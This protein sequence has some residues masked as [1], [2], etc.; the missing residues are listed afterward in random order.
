MIAREFQD[1]VP[2][3]LDKITKLAQILGKEYRVFNS[4]DNFAEIGLEF[5][6]PRK[7][8]NMLL[9][10]VLLLEVGV[11]ITCSQW[12]KS[13]KGSRIGVPNLAQDEAMEYIQLVFIPRLEEMYSSETPQPVTQRNQSEALVKSQ[14]K[15]QKLLASLYANL[16]VLGLSVFFIYLVFFLPKSRTNNLPAELNPKQNQEISACF[17]QQAWEKVPEVSATEEQLQAC[18]VRYICLGNAKA[19]CLLQ[20]ERDWTSCEF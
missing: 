8:S 5:Q 19:S 10:Q 12:I 11:Q 16:G 15:I 3:V 4:S 20:A 2:G 1:T 17:C 6:N 7:E 18:T 14:L 13:W 9:I